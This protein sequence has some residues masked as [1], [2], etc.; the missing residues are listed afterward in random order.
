MIQ[1]NNKPTK[2]SC[3]DCKHYSTGVAA[4]MDNG[5]IHKW[6]ECKKNWGKITPVGVFKNICEL[7]LKL[8]E[9]TNLKEVLP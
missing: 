6:E 8:K 4:V 7:H 5:T 1:P 2:S 3:L 9:E